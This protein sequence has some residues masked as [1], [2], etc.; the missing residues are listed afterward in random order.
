[1]D[2]D[3]DEAKATM[4]DVIH[5]EVAAVV[6]RLVE[7][8]VRCASPMDA[9]RLHKRSFPDSHCSSSSSSVD[10]P[11]TKRPNTGTNTSATLTSAHST[12]EIC[13][14]PVVIPFKASCGD[15]HFHL[16]C[17]LK[18]Y[19]MAVRYR[20]S[21]T[22]AADGST[23][24]LVSIQHY[25]DAF[26][27]RCPKCRRCNNIPTLHTGTSWIKMFNIQ[28]PSHDELAVLSRC[29]LLQPINPNKP[30]RSFSC[31]M[32]KLV[33]P[34]FGQHLRHLRT[35]CRGKMWCSLCGQRSISGAL[36]KKDFAVNIREHL[37]VECTGIKCPHRSVSSLCCSFCPALTRPALA[38]DGPVFVVSD[39]RHRCSCCPVFY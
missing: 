38:H 14:E 25:I 31:C 30:R 28:L 32:C 17:L 13:R 19:S 21:F 3:G 36:T 37:R 4:D 27:T 16:K 35:C 10:D 8:A 24:Q 34:D 9:V 1:M 18:L 6:D 33:Q 5:I 11:K 2:L 39:G 15:H 7:S 12:C 20:C 29:G 26:A 22:I 23:A